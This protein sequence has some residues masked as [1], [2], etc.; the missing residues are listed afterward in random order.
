MLLPYQIPI[1]PMRQEEL[2]YIDSEKD[3]SNI[4]IINGNNRSNKHLVSIYYEQ[5]MVKA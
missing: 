5:D 4:I 2:K 3:D 1:N